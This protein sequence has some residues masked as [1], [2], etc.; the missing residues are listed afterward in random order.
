MPQ[1][2][3]RYCPNVAPI[4]NEYC[5][6]IAPI[7]VFLSPNVGALLGINIG[8]IFFWKIEAILELNSAPILEEILSQHCPNIK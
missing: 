1:Y 7:I 8:A 3:K 2:W 5:P 6:I 4:L